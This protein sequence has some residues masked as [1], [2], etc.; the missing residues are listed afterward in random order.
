MVT[1]LDLLPEE[2]SC[3][4]YTTILISLVDTEEF[5]RKRRH[6]ILRQL[7]RRLSQKQLRQLGL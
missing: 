4:I 6:I 7:C 1:Y 2:L 3:K 5:R